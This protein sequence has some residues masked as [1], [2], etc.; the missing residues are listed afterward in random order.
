[1][2][3]SREG[4]GPHIQKATLAGGFFFRSPDGPVQATTWRPG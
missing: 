4:S 2:A 1:M 3:Q